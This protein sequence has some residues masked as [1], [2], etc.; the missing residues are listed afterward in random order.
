MP[1]LVEESAPRR[2]AVARRGRPHPREEPVHAPRPV[3]LEAEDAAG[4]GDA[5]LLRR[6]RRRRRAGRPPHAGVRTLQEGRASAAFLAHSHIAP[7]APR[8]ESSE[9]GLH[10]AG[11]D[12]A[13]RTRCFSARAAHRLE[14]RE[15][16]GMTHDD[17]EQL[18]PR[19]R[20]PR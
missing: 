1:L 5:A 19:T 20:R 4:V 13:R 16:V 3:A 8:L 17:C 9:A 18:S 14:R 2:V 11:Y 10:Q 12:A 7:A 15:R 6:P